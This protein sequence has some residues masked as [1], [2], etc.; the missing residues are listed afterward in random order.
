MDRDATATGKTK[1]GSVCF[2][3]E[4]FSD[5]TVIAELCSPDLELLAIH[6]K[7]FYSPREISSIILACVYVQP[8]AHADTAQQLLADH[9]TEV[10]NKFPNSIVIVMGDFNHTDLRSELPKYHQLLRCATRGERN[11]DHC[12]SSIKEANHACAR[13]PLGN[14]D[15]AVIKLIPTYRPLLKRQKT[16]KRVVQKWTP[17]AIETLQACFDPTDWR[18]IKLECN[19]FDDY[20]DTCS[21]YIYFCEE[22]C[23]RRQSIVI[24]GNSKP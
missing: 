4:W 7:P 11:L 5:L 1:G 12:Y 21:S 17:A 18:T 22:L 14:G 15:H 9:I 6:C 19:N 2:Y 13:V 20:V 8:Q 24:Y 16:I 3:S 10:E 23:I